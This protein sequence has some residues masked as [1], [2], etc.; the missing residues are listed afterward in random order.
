MAQAAT[1]VS[2][3]PNE[4]DAAPD[5]NMPTDRGSH[6]KLADYK[7]K[8]NV[9]LYFYPKDDTPGCT[10]E[11]KD[12]RD[13]AIEFDKAETVVLGVSKDSV[14]SHCKF[15]DKYS[16]SFMLASDEGGDTTERY[17][18]WGEKNMYGK[19]YMG[20]I[21]ATFLIDKQGRIAR[22]WPK[23]SVDGHAKEALEAAKK[24]A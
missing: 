24:L 7:G 8:K 20:V 14:E 18:A 15:R 3:L 6:V 16:L 5:F 17:G 10:I 4:G 9:V 13:L 12:F 19:K 11:A 22:V 23:V 2:A 1:K 21:R